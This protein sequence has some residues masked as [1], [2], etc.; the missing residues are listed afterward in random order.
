M[1]AVAFMNMD[2]DRNEIIACYRDEFL[3]LFRSLIYARYRDEFLDLFRNEIIACYSLHEHGPV[4][5]LNLL[6]L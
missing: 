4:Q 3:D 1:L 6:F 2:I 5:K